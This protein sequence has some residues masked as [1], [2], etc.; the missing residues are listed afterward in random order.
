M[1]TFYFVK[2]LKGCYYMKFNQRVL[3]KLIE[4]SDSASSLG[5]VPIAAVLV[6]D[7]EIVSYAHNQRKSSCCVFD[8]AEIICITEYA[9]KINDWRLNNCSLYVTVEPCEM[10]KCFIKESRISNVYYLY[11]KLDF[12]KPYNNCS[13]NLIQCDKDNEIYFNKYKNISDLFWKNK[14]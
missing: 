12:K 10:C 9:K 8:H 11:K 14:R 3:K 7:G 2:C 6:C 4:L 13:F 1:C 5:E